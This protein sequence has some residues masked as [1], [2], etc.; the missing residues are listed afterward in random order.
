MS[1]PNDPNPNKPQ[2]QPQQPT[3]RPPV[4]RSTFEF[5]LP[6]GVESYSD[7][8]PV[9]QPEEA[10]STFVNKAAVPPRPNT[11][12][13]ATNTFDFLALPEAEMGP[14]SGPGLQNVA[15]TPPPLEPLP[16]PPLASN[17]TVGL[18]TTSDADPTTFQLAGSGLDLGV[19]PHPVD[20][21]PQPPS[22]HMSVPDIATLFPPEQTGGQPSATSSSESSESSDSTVSLLN[23]GSMPEMEL[24][25]AEAA[26][27]IFDAPASPRSGT[28]DSSLE[29]AEP[30]SEQRPPTPTPIGDWL[31][32]EEPAPA[33]EGGQET[34][35]PSE[36]SPAPATSSAA[37]SSWD[38]ELPEDPSATGE[39][40]PPLAEETDNLTEA[41]PAVPQAVTPSGSFDSVHRP[42]AVPPAEHSKP[43]TASLSSTGAE[44]T[45]P[46]AP[47]TDWI[48]ADAANEASPSPVNAPPPP[49]ESS[50][51]FSGGHL[52]AAEPVEHSDVIAATA[53]GMPSSGLERPAESLHP[54]ESTSS[55]DRL[56]NEATGGEPGSAEL[57]IAREAGSSLEFALPV[58]DSTSI[59]DMPDP[60]SVD[61]LFDSAQAELVPDVAPQPVSPPDEVPD[62]GQSPSETEDAS[63][64][65]A[66]LSNP[67]LTMGSGSANPRLGDGGHG[68]MFELTVP[69][70]PLPPGLFEESTEELPLEGANAPTQPDSDLFVKP[71]SQPEINLSGTPESEHP[72]QSSIFSSEPVQDEPSDLHQAAATEQ[73]LDLANWAAEEAAEFT[74]EPELNATVERNPQQPPV[75]P[76]VPVQRLPHGLSS[77][78]FELS[79]ESAGSAEE[80]LATPNEGAI[81]ELMKSLGD[82]SAETPTKDSRALEEPPVD[83]NSEPVVTVDW[84]AGSAEGSAI[85][86]P[87]R[88]DPEFGSRPFERPVQQMDKPADA[89]FAAP[90]VPKA[91]PRRRDSDTGSEEAVTTRGDTTETA[92]KLI[93]RRAPAKSGSGLVLG[94]LLGGVL[95]SVACAAIYVSGLVPNQEKASNQP[96]PQPP[97]IPRP[98]LPPGLPMPP[99]DPPTPTLDAKTAF[100]LGDWTKAL[101]LARNADTVE[102]KATAGRIRV[103]AKI[104]GIATDADLQQAQ[105]DLR[106]VIATLDQD[107]SPES[108]QRAIQATVDL[109]ISH[110]VSG[111]FEAAKK[112]FTEAKEKYKNHA[113][114]FEALLDRLVSPPADAGSRQPAPRPT[115]AELTHLAFAVSLLLRQDGPKSED[116]PEPGIYYWKA[117][118]R[119][120]ERHYKEAV[121]LIGQAKAAHLRRAQAFAG[122]GLNPLTDPLEQMFPTACDELAALWNE[123]YRQPALADIIQK[124]GLGKT[125]ESLATAKTDLAKA[126]ADAK[127]ALDQLDTTKNELKKAQEE[128]K[129]A[130][131]L[132]EST[133]A[134]LKKTQDNLTLTSDKLKKL[135]TDLTNTTKEL[136]QAKDSLKKLETEKAQAAEAVVAL[137]KDLQKTTEEKNATVAE[138]TKL[139]K[140]LTQ[141][142]AAVS[143]A[144]KLPEKWTAADL[145]A[146]V[147]NLAVVASE[148]EV[149]TLLERLTKA[150]NEAKTATE[151]LATETQRLTE[152]YETTLKKLTATHTAELKT[153]K[154]DYTAQINKLRESNAAEVKKLTEKY[155]ADTK[156]LL[157]EHQ[158]TI[159]K[160][161]NEHMA[162][163]QAEQAKVEAEKKAAAVK[164]ATIEKQLANVI[165]PAQA[166]DIWLPVLTDL[167]RASDADTALEIAKR[168][169]SSSLPD[170]EEAAKARTVQGMAFFLKGE[171]AK[172]HEEFLAARRSP[173]FAEDKPW[174]KVVE[175][176]LEAINDPL[177][178]YRQPVV[179]PAVDSKR[180]VRALDAGIAAYRAGRYPAAEQALLEA[181]KNDP[182]DPVAWYYLGAA[183]WALGQTEQAR[184][185]FQQGA[186]REKVAPQP[187][188]VISM[189][190]APIQG[191]VRDQL[192][193]VRP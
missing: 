78:D 114:I 128:L 39:A 43:S 117:I 106:E 25:P 60:Q 67:D 149:K 24:P 11:L 90:V 3:D 21:P 31:L 56:L 46:V 36:P 23:P 47:V 115:P 176:G 107:N 123:L 51:I 91:S 168:S 166:L 73:E 22:S 181:A 97:Q 124:Q 111:D 187:A 65:L 184:K 135:E 159:K 85:H 13:P 57:P 193:R 93:P 100:A 84:M 50:D 186:E 143:T 49:V 35:G 132:L 1:N 120:R 76:T 95:A 158:L 138:L 121:E 119:A 157:A 118:K 101:E 180:A 178:L 182:A 134:E 63:S 10:D 162:A 44:P 54:S 62:Y 18:G 161:T 40:T 136:T 116:L 110:E 183:R 7:I 64:I 190:I 92:E 17:S 68:P 177:A 144:V 4:D 150:E 165:T 175:N 70:S 102:A 38:I 148:K 58:A 82:D 74:D 30:L 140:D 86:D 75:A 189:A 152:K 55:L 41:I 52:P 188:R 61:P 129:K 142:A 156:K 28:G 103:Y 5:A 185:D 89:T 172:A 169:L 160:L 105:A 87:S 104:R 155:E 137:R 88:T 94:G 83:P 122:R 66:D 153:L 16:E 37:R 125:L 141:I 167:R 151:K 98:P 45:P 12:R 154:D 96:P 112:L 20:L 34:A 42:E 59:H 173:A 179:A 80:S 9:P 191:E 53:Y 69:E 108:R 164:V 171:Y 26:S 32:P 113:P 126:Q 174:A 72:S 170:S 130:S 192:D 27:N 8:P 71:R 133:T 15:A 163:L 79:A 127:R 109:G 99:D 77:S 19:M 81:T 48:D 6:E 139:N 147:K 146:A 29:F 33:P 2:E 131:T 145:S 14:L